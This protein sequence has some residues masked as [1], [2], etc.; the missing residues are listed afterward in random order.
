MTEDAAASPPPEALIALCASATRLQGLE[1]FVARLGETAAAARV[2]ILQHREALDDAALQAAIG[3]A[4]T[5]SDHLAVEAARTYLAPADVIVTLEQNLFRVRPADGLA[6][7][8]GSIDSFLVSLGGARQLNAIAV[9]FAGTGA[10]GTLGVAAIK[11]G[12]GLTLAEHAE[13]DTEKMLATGSTP[14]SLA[15]FILPPKALAER[16]QAHLHH[17]ANTQGQGADSAAV[18]AGLRSIATILRNQTGHDFHGYKRGTFLRRVQRRMQVLDAPDIDS[19][20]ALLRSQPD[21]AQQLFNDLLIGVTQFFRDPREFEILEAQV[22]P[23]L[24]EGKSRTDSVRVWVIGCSTGEEAYSIAILLREYMAKLDEVPQVQIFATDIDGRALAS[25]RAGRYTESAVKEVTPERLA[26]WFVKEGTTYVVAKEL[27]EMCIF[28]QHSV[29]KDA[30]FFRLHLISCRNLLIYLD[31]ALQS[32]VIP[33]FHFA[34]DRGGYLFLG[35]SENVSRHPALFAPIESRH[36]IFRRLDTGARII[37]EFPFAASDRRPTSSPVTVP[38]RAME[39]GLARSAERIAERYAPAYVIIDEQLNVLHF[40]GGMGRYIDPAGGAASLNLLSLVHPDLRLELRAAF[41]R[42]A[43]QHEPARVDNLWIAGNGH[44]TLVDL[45]VEPVQDAPGGARNFV[46]IFKDG[47]TLPDAG[48]DAPAGPSL[49]RDEHIQRLENDLR[50]TRDRLQT[51]VEEHESTNEEL[52]SANE[53]YQSLNEELQSAN[54]ELETSKE[55]LQSV[56]EELTT[57]NGELSHRVQEL[58]R[59]N[60]DLKNLLESTQIGTI[61]L[62]NE[63]RVTNY[64]PAVTELFPLVESDLGRPIGHIRSRVAYEELQED[65][66]RVVRTL[67]SI[68][69]EVADPATGRRYIVRVLPYRSVDNFIG[70]AVVTFTDVTPLTRAQQALRASEERFR[71]VAN[72]VP[73][74]LWST[75]PLGAADWFNKRWSDFTGQ[76]LEELQAGWAETIHPDDRASSRDAFQA[77]VVSGEP[78]ALEHRM[79]RADGAYRWFL[80]RMEPVRNAA[81]AVVQWFGAAT[82]IDDQRRAVET[83]RRSEE[84]AKLLLAELQHRVRNTLGVVRSFARRTADTTE[85]VEDY[86]AH[87][88]GRLGAFARAQ[89]A[90]TQNPSAGVSLE[91]IIADE[92]ASFGAR[93]GEQVSLEGPQVRLASKTAEVFTLA[94]HELAT[95]AVKY[96]ALRSPKGRIRVR[97]RMEDGEQ[98]RR[99]G[100]EWAESAELDSAA[101]SRR[102]FGTELLE[103][104]VPYELNGEAVLEYRPDGLVCRIDLPV[105]GNLLPA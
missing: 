34:L 80:V 32:R 59:A 105:D 100:L 84:Q 94:I 31:A 6:G 29:I 101:P 9:L 75:D 62:D 17:L 42:A 71:A 93:E 12:G 56:N 70:G 40:S 68:D 18:A 98:G 57:V 51:T 13:E 39:A 1:K 24:F 58:G 97:W 78:L 63:L 90:V 19:Y 61:F 49:L 47:V 89:A 83:A 45:A 52:K 85:S 55:E 7:Q 88:D 33:L 87:L 30:P 103:R 37:P 104:M 26:R 36:R 91:R 76:S 15:D 48:G 20:L 2:V 79:R 3:E 44:R 102:G 16:V 60:S 46:V 96:G 82:D 41:N 86:A 69:R 14:A 74:L 92:I 65:V 23:R 10:D 73:D 64:T 5:I 99:L 4:I 21:E 35:G 72:L 95:N 77:A 28:S 67:A 11:E 25:A 22:I 81:E 8:R 38:Q 66:R 50:T 27:R 54:E 53:E 43:E